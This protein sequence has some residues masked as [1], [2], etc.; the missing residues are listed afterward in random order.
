M[1]S[2]A[3]TGEIAVPRA[4]VAESATAAQTPDPLAIALDHGELCPSNV[5]AA[6]AGYVLPRIA[7]RG[8]GRSG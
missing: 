3:S 5:R 1:S 2:I 7:A 6:A 8:A 4:I